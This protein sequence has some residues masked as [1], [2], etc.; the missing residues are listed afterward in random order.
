MSLLLEYPNEILIKIFT[1]LVDKDLKELRL[2]DSRFEK[3]IDTSYFW[4]VKAIHDEYT[5]MTAM[6][7][8][9]QVEMEVP[10]SEDTSICNFKQDAP[11]PMNLYQQLKYQKDYNLLLKKNN[12]RRKGLVPPRVPDLD[13]TYFLEDREYMVRRLNLACAHGSKNSI[14]NALK[15]MRQEDINIPPGVVSWT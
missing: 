9:E 15:V 5:N 4:W 14:H 1:E 12:N 7:F 13:V 6:Q 11:N 3:I 8:K 2:V 10:N